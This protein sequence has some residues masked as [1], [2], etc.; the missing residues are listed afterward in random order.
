MD[1]QNLEKLIDFIDE[2]S[3]L[4]GNEWFC[5][6]LLIKLE[7][8]LG[9]VFRQESEYGELLSD[10]KRSRHYL[11][12]IDKNT[13]KEA[14]T[15]YSSIKYTDVKIELIH[16]YKEMKIADKNDDIIEYTRRIVMQLENCLNAICHITNAYEKIKLSPDRFRSTSTDLVRG[17]YSFF[18]PDGTPKQYSKISIQSKVFYAKQLY[19]IKYS[20][21]DMTEMITIRNKSSHRGEYSEKERKIIDSAKNNMAEKKSNYFICYDTFWKKMEDLRNIL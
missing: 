21:P 19:D 4:P 10:I 13:W 7:P 12:N 1:R 20:Y 16:D 8:H 3:H 6:N 14:F 11:R 15:Y 9:S 5:K 17:D 18:L 2:L